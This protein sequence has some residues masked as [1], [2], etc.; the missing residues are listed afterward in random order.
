MLAEE[1]VEVLLGFFSSDA[2][3]VIIM[4]VRG[5]S[6]QRENVKRIIETA[7]SLVSTE[8]NLKP[9]QSTVTQQW[10]SRSKF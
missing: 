9:P 8:K 5:S 7:R 4:A 10:T 2:E 3:R 6:A 1:E